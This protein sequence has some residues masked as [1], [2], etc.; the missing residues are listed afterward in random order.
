VQHTK[1]IHICSI[2]DWTEMTY[3]YLWCCVMLCIYQLI[4][5]DCLSCVVVWSLVFYVS[6]KYIASCNWP[7]NYQQKLVEAYNS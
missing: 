6:I 2:A 7:K 4:Y 5:W 3:W 1:D